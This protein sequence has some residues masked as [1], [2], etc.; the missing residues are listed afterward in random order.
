MRTRIWAVSVALGAVMLAGGA[1]A[2]PASAVSAP[3][4]VGYYDTIEEC[5]SQRA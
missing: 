1:I 4:L 5:P 3:A 2:A